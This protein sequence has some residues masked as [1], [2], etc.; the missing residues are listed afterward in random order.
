MPMKT[1]TTLRLDCRCALRHNADFGEESEAIVSARQ[2][3][4]D[5]Q[6]LIVFSMKRTNTAQAWLH[7]ALVST[8]ERHH[9]Q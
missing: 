4:P 9:A 3:R 5:G 6:N 8:T 1:R 2:H 7:V